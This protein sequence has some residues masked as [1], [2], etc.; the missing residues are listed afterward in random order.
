[1]TIDF[2]FRFIN[3]LDQGE[4]RHCRKALKADKNRNSERQSQLFEVLCGLKTFDRNEFQKRVEE[5][6]VSSNLSVEKNRLYERLIY[7]VKTLHWER[8]S[9]TDPRKRVEE[10]Q[11]LMELALYE[12]AK[13]KVLKG[14]TQAIATE[15]L[16][17]EVSLRELLR[18]ILKNLPRT[19][20][21]DKLITSNE[22]QLQTAASKL[23][24]VISYTQINDRIYDYHRK[25]RVS[26]AEGV[27]QGIQELMKRPEMQ[28]LDHADS[29]PSQIRF[30]YATSLAQLSEMNYQDALESKKKLVKLW[31]SNPDRIEILPAQYRSA[32]S[33]LLGVMAVAGQ[34][35]GALDYLKRM[36]SILPRGRRDEI[37]QFCDVELQYFLYFINTGQPDMAL[38]RETIILDG[39]KRYGKQLPIRRHLTFLYNL[40]VTHLICDN[41][42]RALRLFD[43]IRQ[44]GKLDA[45]QDIQGVSRLLRLLLL[46]EQDFG[47]FAHYLR[48]SQTFFS[49]QDRHYRLENI[50][51]RWLENHHNLNGTGEQKMSFRLLAKQ[52]DPLV[53]QKTLG[54]EEMSFW[55]EARAQNTSVRKMY[56]QSLNP[57]TGG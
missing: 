13:E 54:A 36:E 50:V 34:L 35:D 25:F 45:R 40:G 26:D 29:L 52:L 11:V 15:E 38:K 4:L 55:A 6:G 39:I 42:G 51:Y 7:L 41:Y 46:C 2:L 31:E 1:M 28:S 9:K 10:G 22:Y 8:G 30:L 49:V 19:K 43:R 12:E 20:Q 44:L 18:K 47:T 24:R 27:K 33:N 23:Q 3:A 48:N 17:I 37:A 53:K 21:N 14:L 57:E 56:E 16:L 32:I 5:Y